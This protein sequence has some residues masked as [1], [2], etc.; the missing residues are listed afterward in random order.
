MYVVLELRYHI[1]KY[2]KVKYSSLNCAN[3]R[4]C[5]KELL[6]SVKKAMDELH[7]MDLCH[8]D[9]RIPN[10]IC[11]DQHYNAVLKGLYFIK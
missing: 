4:K 2:K 5:L 10:T 6:G 3:A 8:N 7:R 1:Y 11:F 9:I